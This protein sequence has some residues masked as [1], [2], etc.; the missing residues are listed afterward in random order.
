MVRFSR[1]VTQAIRGRF[2]PVA[3]CTDGESM[4]GGHE[5]LEFIRG[6]SYAGKG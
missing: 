1:R 5:H 6:R 3:S 4:G 2:I